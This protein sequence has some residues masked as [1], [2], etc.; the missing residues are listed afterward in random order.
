MPKALNRYFSTC[1]LG[2]C[3]ITLIGCGS[4]SGPSDVVPMVPQERAA[5]A[6]DPNAGRAA[7]I[8]RGP[9]KAKDNRQT[10]KS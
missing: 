2:L 9:R 1:C 8:Q 5:D 6:P 4:S 3:L 10:P 7:P